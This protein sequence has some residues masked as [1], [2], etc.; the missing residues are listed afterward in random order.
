MHDNDPLWKKCAR[1]AKEEVAA[2]NQVWVGLDGGNV[3]ASLFV[4]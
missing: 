3:M 1:L 2:A 4:F